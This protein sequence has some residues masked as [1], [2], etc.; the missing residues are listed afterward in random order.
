MTNRNEFIGHISACLGRD[1]LPPQPSRLPYQ[2]NV[3]TKVMA[4]WRQEKIAAA[5]M[6]YSRAIGV[7]VVETLKQNLN[8]T[9]ASTATALGSATCL[10]ADEPLFEEMRTRVVLSSHFPVEVWDVSASRQENVQRADKAMVG[11]A[12]A[13]C[14]LAESA[15]VLLFSRGGA[16]RSVTLLPEAAIYVVPQS[17]IRPRI[18]QTMAFIREHLAEGLPS[19]INLVSGPSATSD[20]ELVRVVGVHGPMRVAHVVVR[21]M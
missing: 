18:T 5:F 3:H 1:D 13:E 16:G 20:I 14:A 7:T 6:D 12:V 17:V 15:T 8:E 4:G 2:H 10:L 19:S 11:I 9:L 21:D